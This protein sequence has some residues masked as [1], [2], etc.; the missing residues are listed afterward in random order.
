MTDQ[1][2]HSSIEFRRPINSR[3][4]S[5][6]T[7]NLRSIIQEIDHAANMLE[8]AAFD[9]AGEIQPARVATLMNTAAALQALA[10]RVGRCAG[11]KPIPESDLHLV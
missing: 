9:L 2:D 4:M 1:Q 8:N 10:V 3:A 5:G 11:S 6:R 7:L